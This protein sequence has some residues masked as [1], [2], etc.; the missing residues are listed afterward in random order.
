MSISDT[1]L[2]EATPEIAYLQQMPKVELHV[3]L[4]GALPP[5]TLLKLARKYNHPI[6]KWTEMQLMEWFRFKDF[7]HF[8]K[9]YM[10]ICECIQTPEDIELLTYEFLQG[11]AQQNIVHTEF[12]FTAW[13]HHKNRQIPYPELFAAVHQGCSRAELDFGVTSLV[14]VDIPRGFATPEEALTMTKHVVEAERYGV[15]A[16]G[17]GGYEVGNPVE[18]YRD[19]FELAHSANLTCILHAGET[20]GAASIWEALET[21]HSL[22][23]GHG[24]RCLE[25]PAL[26]R[27]LIEHQIPLEVCPTSNVCLKVV[28]SFEKHPLP[29]LIEQGLLV[30]LNSDDPA[31]FSTTLTDE[32]V[33]CHQKLGL[34]IETLSGLVNNAMQVSLAGR[35]DKYLHHRRTY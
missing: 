30:T 5:A 12:T 23:I 22:R 7:P 6:G 13:I 17:L 18:V 15:A 33:Q 8:A 19:S 10:T 31:L 25:D 20:E 16:L 29:Q 3:H 32:Y 35:F 24:V 1:I 26:V 21:G 11:Q 28:E 9:S 27:Y 4:E 34:S 14:I 2:L